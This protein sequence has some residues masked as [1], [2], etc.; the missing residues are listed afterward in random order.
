MNSVDLLQL[1]SERDIRVTRNGVKL[2]IDA[3]EGTLDEALRGLLTLHKSELLDFLGEA[4]SLPNA[5][6]AHDEKLNLSVDAHD[7]HDAHIQPS[8]GSRH[9]PSDGQLTETDAPEKRSGCVSCASCVTD[10]S[11]AIVDTAACAWASTVG[12]AT[13]PVF[14]ST[15]DPIPVFLDFETQSL[16]PL[17]EL[18]GRVYAAHASTRV[19]CAVAKLPTGGW[20]AWTPSDSPPEELFALVAAGVPVVAHNAYGFDKFVWEKLGWPTAVWIDTL[21]IA[22]LSGLPGSLDGIGEILLGRPKDKEGQRLTRSLSRPDRKTGLLPVVTPSILARVKEYC[23]SDVGLLAD[24]W[25]VLAG[26]AHLEADVRA[27][28]VAINERGFAFDAELA[29]AVIDCEARLVCE[30]QKAASVSGK[31]LASQPQLRKWLASAGVLVKDIRRGTIEELLDEP[32]LPDDVR[33]VI[34]ARLASSTITSNKLRAALRRQGTDGRV[35]DTLVYHA[36]HT[37]RWG[38]RAFQPQNLPRGVKDLDIDAAIEAAFARDLDQLRELATAVGA[39]VGEV[40]AT[41]VRTCVHAPPG[42]ILGVIDYASI[43]ARALAWISRDEEAL[44]GYRRGECPYKIMATTLFGVEL[45]QVSKA[46][47]NLGKVPVL[48]CGYQM[49]AERLETYSLAFNID[50]MSLPVTPAQVVEAWRDAH[51]LVA[52]YRTGDVYEGHVLREGGLWRDLEQA[53][54]RAAAGEHV[55]I[56]YFAW[57]RVGNAVTC[58]LPSGRKLVYPGAQAGPMPTRWGKMKTTFSYL[59]RG[60]RIGTYGG[61]L[62]ENITQ[63]VCRDLLADALV[64]LERRG[65]PAVLHV[66]DEVV[67]ELSCVAELDEMKAIMSSVPTWAEGLL[68]GVD[69]YAEAR[70]RK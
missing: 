29:H 1:L 35:R 4:K 65:F 31:V 42:R 28:D 41:L 7:T 55:E 70:Y 64:R 50:W 47:R 8:T 23:T 27:V 6:D 60:N 59:H 24:A 39:S 43:E 63:A 40:L 2:A 57:D 52:G 9:V 26:A 38:G 25:P 66:H 13:V 44:A 20:L 51:P 16:A 15:T 19:L 12:F 3:P 14:K 34:V 48:G 32:D 54:L 10:K 46:Q 17:D 11:A 58:T 53:A 5:P 37:G 62:T 18:G 22:R 49:G 33:R 21:P 30:L 56:S 67:S 68:L 61:K 36:A 45:G 69:G